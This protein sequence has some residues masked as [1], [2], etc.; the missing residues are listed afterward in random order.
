MYLITRVISRASAVNDTGLQEGRKEDDGVWQRRDDGYD[1][2]AKSRCNSRPLLTLSLTRALTRLCRLGATLCQVE[3][4]LDLASWGDEK[5]GLSI[6]NRIEATQGS[7]QEAYD[8]SSTQL[9]VCSACCCVSKESIMFEIEQEEVQ[10]VNIK[11]IKPS[12]MVTAT[13]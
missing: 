5:G 13:K 11:G 7:G 6:M 8:S 3:F 4:Q 1:V 9:I 2:A 10:G 12:K